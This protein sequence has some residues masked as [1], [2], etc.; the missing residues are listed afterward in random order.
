MFQRTQTGLFHEMLDPVVFF[1]SAQIA[2]SR[3]CRLLLP[4]PQKPSN[5]QVSTSESFF[6][7]SLGLSLSS[8]EDRTVF[9]NEMV[10]HTAP[11]CACCCLIPFRQHD[12]GLARLRK[13]RPTMPM[14][15]RSSLSVASDASGVLWFW[16]M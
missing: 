12:H 14:Q 7:I 16:M 6:A 13:L 8:W 11:S 10:F 15:I 5:W 3:R 2:G 9:D 1:K 4:S